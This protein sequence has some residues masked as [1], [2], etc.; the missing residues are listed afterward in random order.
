MNKF[1]PFFTDIL[2]SVNFTGR[3]NQNGCFFESLFF[4]WAITK[5]CSAAISTNLFL[6]FEMTPNC[7]NTISNMDKGCQEIL[8]Q[9]KDFRNSRKL[10]K[11]AAIYKTNKLVLS[12]KY[13]SLKAKGSEKAPYFST[14]H[15]RGMLIVIFRRKNC[16][17]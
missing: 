16:N 2:P 4:T 8:L 3:H 11:A 12:K 10:N 9:S 6:I 17:K 1:F 13:T 15:F 5:K 7:A 14:S